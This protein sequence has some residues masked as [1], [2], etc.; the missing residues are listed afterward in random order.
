MKKCLILFIGIAFLNTVYSQSGKVGINTTTPA[1]MLH[2]KDSSVLFSGP[3]SITFP[4]S[5]PPASDAGVRMMWYPQKAAFRAGYVDGQQ[6]NKD[7]IGLYSF[8]AGQNTRAKGD[9]SIAMGSD[10]TKAD[11]AFSVAL[12][13]GT[14]A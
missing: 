3:P 8:A 1:A 10:Y 12:G 11:G 13:G 5:P 2:V 6:W 9:F 7:S 14:R 4:Y